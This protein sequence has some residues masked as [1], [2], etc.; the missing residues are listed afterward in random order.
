[1]VATTVVAVT[2]I[3][4]LRMMRGAVAEPP[5]VEQL[6]ALAPEIADFVR[7]ERQQVVESPRSAARWARFAMAC[8]ANGL[9]SAA[10]DAYAVAATLE[11]SQAK[12]TFHRA[13]VDGRLGQVDDA[14]R[15]MRRVIKIDPRFAPAYW[16]LGLLLLDQNHLDDAQ[17]AFTRATELDPADRA[18]WL[19]LARVFLQ[20]DDAANAAQILERLAAAGQADPYALQILGTA[21]RRLGRG[22]ESASALAAG[23]R[24]E[25]QWNDPWTDEMLGF[26]RG[27][28]ALLKEATAYIV[29]GQFPPAIRI[30]EQLRREKPND[31]VLLAHLG[32]VY[33]AAGDDARG[34]PLLEQVAAAAPERFEALVDLATGY[35]H[36]DNLANARRT[37]DRAIS[38]NP[39]YAPAYE[40]LGLVLWREGDPRAAIAAFE[41]AVRRDPRNARALVWMGM[42]YTNMDKPAEAVAAFQRS[43]KADPTNVDAWIGIANGEMN[44]RD[45]NAASAAL[46]QAQRLQPDRAAVKQTTDR[47][48]SMQRAR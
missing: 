6:G 10:R 31:V 2:S 42:A 35:M 5:A 30:L 21:Y 38:I 23:V 37:V 26:R 8:E 19:G 7:Q 4:A 11:P 16:R 46:Q 40:T 27:Y 41:D 29:A 28:A 22:D 1:M 17:R 12:W 44:R 34:V 15:G 3:V 36:Q 18:G 47:L 14:V 48:Q 45:L 43:T 24:G 20:R 33:V 9:P 39:S 32:Q 25:P 13:R